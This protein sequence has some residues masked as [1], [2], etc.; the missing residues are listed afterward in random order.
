MGYR[1]II[2]RYVAKSHSNCLRVMGYRSDS[3]A[4][5]RDM[6]PLRTWRRVKKGIFFPTLFGTPGGEAW[7]DLLETFRG[8]RGSGVWRPLYM[9]IAIVCP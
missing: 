3:I 2:V 6:G 5:S 1:A 8:F 9:D 4:I 7:D